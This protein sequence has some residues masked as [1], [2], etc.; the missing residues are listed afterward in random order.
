MTDGTLVEHV[1]AQLTTLGGVC[2][3]LLGLMQSKEQL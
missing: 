2:V 1:C 3:T